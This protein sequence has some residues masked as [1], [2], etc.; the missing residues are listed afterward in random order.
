MNSGRLFTHVKAGTCPRSF[1]RHCHIAEARTRLLSLTHSQLISGG[2]DKT[3]IGSAA[4]SSTF[5]E[6]EPPL[7]LS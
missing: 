2:L 7:F 5:Q 3:G 6:T 1:L 4:Y